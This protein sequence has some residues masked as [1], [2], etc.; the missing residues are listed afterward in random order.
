[1][2]DVGMVYPLRAAV[3]VL[4]VCCETQV[5]VP[6]DVDVPWASER[7]PTPALDRQVAPEHVVWCRQQRGGPPGEAAW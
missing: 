3:H 2:P 5:N 6:L 7:V 4:P 1:M